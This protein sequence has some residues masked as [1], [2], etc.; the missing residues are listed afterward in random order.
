MRSPVRA[1][2]WEQWRQVWW[3]APIAVVTTTCAS[4]ALHQDRDIRWYKDV[5][6]VGTNTAII[7]SMTLAVG[8]IL[9]LHSSAKDIRAGIPTRHMT[10]PVRSLTLSLTQYL[11][12]LAFV[13]GL[14]FALLGIAALIDTSYTNNVL[15][16][17]A[18][19]ACAMALLSAVM[20][21]IGRRR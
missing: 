4:L 2:L 15:P 9:F 21:T 1:L 14:A 3:T 16:W 17:T 8:L 20:W 13:V 11:F 19:T 6:W 7:A 12:R 5:W 18:F 10:L